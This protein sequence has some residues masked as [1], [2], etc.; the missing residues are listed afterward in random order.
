MIPSIAARIKRSQRLQIAPM[1]AV[2]VVLTLLL[3]T[4]L[5]R[6]ANTNIL[7]L[8]LAPAAGG[9]LM[10]RPVLAPFALVLA[11]LLVRAEFGTGTD[12]KLSVAFLLVPMLLALW[13]LDSVAH[14]RK[15]NA[16]HSRTLPP[17]FLFVLAGLL[18]LL[19]G[20]VLW[21]SNVPR[22]GNLILVQLTQW[23][24]FAFS[25]GAFWLAAALIPNTAWL[26]RLTWSFLIT[27]GVLIALRVTPGLSSLAERFT[28]AALVWPPATTL[29]TALAGGQLFF[30]RRLSRGVRIL[31]LI[32]LAAIAF[33]GFVLRRD[34]LSV[35]V[36]VAVALGVLV[37]LRLPRSRWP[38]VVLVIALAVSGVLFPSL[39][40]FAG[41]EEEWVGS[42]G[43]RLV[44]IQ[45]VIEVT[46]RN[47]ITGLGPA[48]YRH[49]AI[50]KP[51][52]YLGAYWLQPWV[53]SHNNYVDLFAHVGLLGLALFGWFAVAFARTGL[54]LRWRYTEGFAAGYLNGMLAAGAASLVL[55]A[56]ADWILPHVYNIGFPGFQASV[57]V[58]LFLGGVVALEN[59]GHGDGGTRGHGDTETRGHGDTGTRRRG[60]WE[61]RGML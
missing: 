20:T 8:L 22:S 47:P 12:V 54:R 3:A 23:A 18:S 29:L 58:W 40:D 28:S 48:A 51:L 52:P 59:M 17:L 7:I 13:I 19:I 60:E 35:W 50:M 15:L 53:N 41:G 11:A 49:Y 45:R 1:P 9:I 6:R 38:I 36:G 39:Y 2:V 55:M 33:Y 32:M 61:S 4:A 46:M 26:R 10:I 31:L 42:G 37:W 5:G 27:G 34:D 44:L 14:R 24:I 16:I 56:F 25:A 30:N 21:D 57:L 43:S